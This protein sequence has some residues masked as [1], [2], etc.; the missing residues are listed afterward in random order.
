MHAI[1]SCHIERWKISVHFCR[2]ALAVVF[3]VNV[4][5]RVRVGARAACDVL[6]NSLLE[7]ADARAFLRAGKHARNPVEK[8]I[9]A[10]SR[11]LWGF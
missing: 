11:C 5:V 6:M 2:N 4:R 7:F 1:T 8:T 3:A 9:V 10:A